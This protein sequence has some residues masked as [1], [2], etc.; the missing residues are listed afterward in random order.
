[1]HK[2]TA[3]QV[4]KWAGITTSVLLVVFAV[5]WYAAVLY[6]AVYDEP[7][8]MWLL[9]VAGILFLAIIAA[10]VCIAAFIWS[11]RRQGSDASDDHAA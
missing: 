2:G 5:S 1:M 7:F 10:I 9:V 4:S 6:D 3:S 11:R 8:N